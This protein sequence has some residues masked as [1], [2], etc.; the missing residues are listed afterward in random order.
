MRQGQYTITSRDVYEY[1][2]GFFQRHLRLM[3]HGPEC[4]AGVLLAVLYYACART[5]SLAAAC[6]SLRDAPSDTAARSASLATLPAISELQRRLN[7]ALQG[8][9]LGALRRRPQPPA[10]DLTLVPYHGEHLHNP[11]EVYRSAAKGVAGQD[12]GAGL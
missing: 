1:A 7:R 3:D 4:T 8:D 10:V 6:A 2:A 11:D 9:L 12:V 5:S